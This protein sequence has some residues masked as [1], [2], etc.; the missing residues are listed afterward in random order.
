MKAPFTEPSSNM[1]PIIGYIM[2]FMKGV[3]FHIF[4]SWLSFYTYLTI[5]IVG[6]NENNSCKAVCC[7]LFYP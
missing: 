2:I 5:F 1:T 3:Y 7:Y 6:K 4:Y